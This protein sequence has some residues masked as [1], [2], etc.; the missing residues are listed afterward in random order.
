MDA[1]SHKKHF[2]SSTSRFT[3]YQNDLI[4][5][6]PLEIIFFHYDLMERLM[7]F[8]ITICRKD[9]YHYFPLEYNVP[10]FWFRSRYTHAS[11]CGKDD[12]S[13]GKD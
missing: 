12:Y 2:K 8:A 5:L 10:K 4:P 6:H 11:L 7:L 1:R 13:R 9:Y 3:F